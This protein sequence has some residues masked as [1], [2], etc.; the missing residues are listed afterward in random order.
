MSMS[1]RGGP[2]RRFSRET[3]VFGHWDASGKHGS[4]GEPIWVKKEAI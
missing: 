4:R 3:F 2:R 1:L